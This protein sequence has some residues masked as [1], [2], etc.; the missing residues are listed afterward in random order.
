M[1]E[2]DVSSPQIF[3]VVW[4]VT[5]RRLLDSL[6]IKACKKNGIFMLR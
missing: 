6:L 1:V 3:I 4:L 2:V 5:L